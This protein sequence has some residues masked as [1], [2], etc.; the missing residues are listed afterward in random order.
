MQPRCSFSFLK[1]TSLGSRALSR[2]LP[3][4][5]HFYLLYPKSRSQIPITYPK[6]PSGSPYRTYHLLPPYYPLGFRMSPKPK[7]SHTPLHTTPTPHV[8]YQHPGV[9]RQPLVRNSYDSDHKSLTRC[10]MRP[11]VRKVRWAARVF[12]GSC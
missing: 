10:N 9:R 12:A 11:A 2:A 8:A 7:I 1:R 4:P 6:S 5:P 3:L